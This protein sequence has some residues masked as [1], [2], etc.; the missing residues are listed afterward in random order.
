MERALGQDF[1]KT[2]ER[3]KTFSLEHWH[4]E[5]THDPEPDRGRDD[6]EERRRERDREGDDF[7]GR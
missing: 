2:G 7:F 3:D 4:A 6:D 5:V 1:D